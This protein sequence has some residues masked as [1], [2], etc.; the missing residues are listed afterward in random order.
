MKIYISI[1]YDTNP[2][3]IT[4]Y[5]MQQKEGS[6]QKEEKLK[7]VG[8][9]CSIDWRVDIHT[10]MPIV[11]ELWRAESTECRFLPKKVISTTTF[12]TGL[13]LICIWADKI[14]TNHMY[15]IVS[16]SNARY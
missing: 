4:H 15:R 11:V 16:S 8:K 13:F 5:S 9:K 2:K 6:L 1:W 3:K 7:K 14:K 12:M 10:S